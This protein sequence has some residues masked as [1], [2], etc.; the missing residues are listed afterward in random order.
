MKSWMP[1]AKVTVGAIVG[2]LAW[3]LVTVIPA[4]HKGLP[5]DV[6][7]LLPYVAAIIAAYIT[8]LEKRFTQTNV[9][10]NSVTNL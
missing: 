1:I 4:W 7:A 9:G 10:Q 3:L 6:S 2:F 5:A 8:K